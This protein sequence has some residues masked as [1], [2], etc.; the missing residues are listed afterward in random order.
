MII[1]T[2]APGVRHLKERAARDVI[3]VDTTD[4]FICYEEALPGEWDCIRDRAEIERI[5]S[6]IERETP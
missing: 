6:D 4:G 2:I 3:V 5:L 1:I